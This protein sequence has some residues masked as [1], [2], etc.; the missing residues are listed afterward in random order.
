M[1]K[2]ISGANFDGSDELLDVGDE[3]DNKDSGNCAGGDL[4]IS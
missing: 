1:P 3:M 2:R 4:V